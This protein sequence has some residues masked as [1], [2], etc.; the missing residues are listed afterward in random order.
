MTK[1]YAVVI[2]AA[3]LC[4]RCPQQLGGDGE[5][6]REEALQSALA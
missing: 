2:E 1:T 3:G 6:V 4:G 5:R